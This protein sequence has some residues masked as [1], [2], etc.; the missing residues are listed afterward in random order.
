MNFR[1]KYLTILLVRWGFCNIRRENQGRGK[2]YESL[3]RR[4]LTK[5]S[6][7]PNITKASTKNCCFAL[8]SPVWGSLTGSQPGLFTSENKKALGSYWSSILLASKEH[9]TPKGDYFNFILK[10]EQL[11]INYA[12]WNKMKVPRF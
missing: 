2:S 4:K 8:F 5:T 9:G 3:W 10:N 12:N 7:I 1:I 11:S 6:I